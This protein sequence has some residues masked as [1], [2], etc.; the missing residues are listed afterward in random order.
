LFVLF[1]ELAEL[2]ADCFGGLGD[3]GF[4]R[5]RAVLDAELGVEEAEKVIDFGDG[6]DGGFSAAA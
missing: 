3:D 2:V 4:A 5:L 6:A 1:E